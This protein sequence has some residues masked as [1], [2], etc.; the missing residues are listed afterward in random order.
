MLEMLIASTLAG[1]A[2]GIGAIPVLFIKKISH[3]INDGMLGFA[4][5]VMVAAS[6]FSLI[7]PALDFGS[8]WDVVIGILAGVLVLAFIDSV[9]PHTHPG[10]S[11]LGQPSSNVWRR[12]ILMII[13]ITLHNIPEGL[14]VGVGYGADQAGLGL[15][16]AIAIAAQNAPEGLVVAAPLREQ[17]VSLWK[18][19]LVV[20]ATGLVEPIGALLGFMVVNIATGLLPFALAFAAGAMLFVVSSELM[21]ETHGHGYERTATMSFIIGFLLMLIINYTL[22]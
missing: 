9:L 15:V 7:L 17:G 11:D 21:P 22:G 6:C 1:L 8:I 18:I 14:S 19:L 2:T 20:T 12:A 13:A 4:A 3:R 5:G 16:I 10:N